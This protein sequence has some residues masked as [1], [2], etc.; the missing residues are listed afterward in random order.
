M[1]AAH[2]YEF[3]K[4]NEIDII[5]NCSKDIPFIYDINEEAK[6]NLSLET[7]RIPVNDSLLEKDFILMEQWFHIILPIIMDKYK[8]NKKILIN[9]AAG[10]QRS[11]IFVAA[12]L[13]TMLDN[14]L[15]IDN[16][17]TN[18]N[19][20]IEY[21]NIINFILSKR[22]HAFTF[23]FKINFEKSYKRYFNIT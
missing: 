9:C 1:Y 18:D 22:Y 15:K 17:E 21:N 5:V 19:K 20:T 6:T 8:E 16:L 7:Y 10:K 11:A 3:L 13:K 4:E 2:N 14:G 12:L 23:G